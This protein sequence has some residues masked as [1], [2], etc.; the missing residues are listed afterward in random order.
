MTS[1]SIVRPATQRD[2]AGV[3]KLFYQCYEENGMSAI[4]PSKVE[5]HIDRLINPANIIADDTGPRGIIGV[6]GPPDDLEGCIMVA[7]N[8]KWYSDEI[9]LDEY[10]NYVDPRFRASNHSKS[11]IGYAKD[12]TDKLRVGHPTLHLVIGVLS[13]T[14][15][16]AKVRLYRQQLRECGSFFLYPVP[17]DLP[18]VNEKPKQ[19]YG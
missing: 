4:S 7:F 17:P 5:Y 14:R 8:T 10:L 16:A 12:M 1:P 15:T 6:I 13:T 3:W 18:V 9:T 19:R 11:L 2:K